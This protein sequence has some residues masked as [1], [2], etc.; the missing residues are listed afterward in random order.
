MR[1]TI[2]LV[3]LTGCACILA[4]A[5]SACAA[6]WRTM[7][8]TATAYTLAEDETKQGNVGLSAW[9]DQLEPGMRAIAVS[10]DLI[11]K[12]LGHGAKVKIEGLRGT[13]VV[14]DKMNRRWKNKIDIL[15]PS[16]KLARKWG[17]QKV[18]IRWKPTSVQS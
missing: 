5:F 13:Y 2:N 9:G 15:F 17:K 16:K 11:K 12:G 1:Y 3:R 6:D 10:R 4:A 7:E 18:T 14:R 8:V